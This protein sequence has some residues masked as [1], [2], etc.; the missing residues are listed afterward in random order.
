[1]QIGTAFLQSPYSAD[2]VRRFCAP[3]HKAEVE[4]SV[5]RLNASQQ[6]TWPPGPFI[7]DQAQSRMVPSEMHRGRQ[8]YD[9]FSRVEFGPVPEEDLRQLT[10]DFDVHRR[11]KLSPQKPM[12]NLELLH[13]VPLGRTMTV[14]QEYPASHKAVPNSPEAY[15]NRSYSYPNLETFVQEVSS[16]CPQTIDSFPRSNLD[17]DGLTIPKVDIDE[18]DYTEGNSVI[19]SD[20]PQS[21]SVTPSSVKI[22]IAELMGSAADYEVIRTKFRAVSEVILQDFKDAFIDR[23]DQPALAAG[24]QAAEELRPLLVQL[25]CRLCDQALFLMVEWVRA[26]PLFKHLKVIL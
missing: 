9:S 5:A 3:E 13:P 18:M 7:D 1:M 24:G 21:K 6:Q 26:A 25:F 17:S 16:K 23:Y 15:R 8:R 12:P 20:L 4:P 14:G 11:Q 19:C 22:S 2:I 10:E